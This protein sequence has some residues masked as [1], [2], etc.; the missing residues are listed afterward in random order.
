MN[1]FYA[2]NSNSL[3][4][5]IESY[6]K[7][8]SVRTAH[9]G[10]EDGRY[11]YEKHG[12]RIACGGLVDTLKYRFCPHYKDNRS[13]RNWRAKVRGSSKE[14]GKKVDSQLLEYVHT[15]KPPKKMHKMTDS[16]LNYWLKKRNHTL[17]ASQLPVEIEGGWNKM[18][19]ADIITRDNKTGDLYLWE[20]KTGF[21]VGGFR[22]QGYFKAPFSHVKCTKYNMWQLQL[23]Y[24]RQA[25]EQKGLHFKEAN[26]IQ[27]YE[28][29]KEKDLIIKIHPQESWLTGAPKVATTKSYKPILL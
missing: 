5:Q 27:I 8:D 22:K 20:V 7:N 15:G 25:L 16:L 1:P 21:P 29:K 23:H 11:H 10:E 19:Q 24:T 12:Q 3:H 4:P 17:Q 26:V 9:F 18:T 14:Q 2:V 13:K 6:I 28:K